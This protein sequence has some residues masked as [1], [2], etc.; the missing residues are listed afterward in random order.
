MSIKL[1]VDASA[2]IDPIPTDA[3]GIVRGATITVKGTAGC[4]LVY[5]NK[6]RVVRESLQEYTGHDAI[7]RVLA[8]GTATAIVTAKVAGAAAKET[9]EEQFDSSPAGFVYD[10]LS[11]GDVGEAAVRFARSAI[12]KP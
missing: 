8:A 6:G 10:V 12:H 7:G 4:V 1:I 2:G 3:K 9:A 5:D 11:R